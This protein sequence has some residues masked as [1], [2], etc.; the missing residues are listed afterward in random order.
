MCVFVKVC[1]LFYL[2]THTQTP[3]G[4]SRHTSSSNIDTHHVPLRQI[5]EKREENKGRQIAEKGEED[6]G[7]DLDGH[8]L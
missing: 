8:N 1:I 7:W 5:V 6:K 4:L 2:H 3:A